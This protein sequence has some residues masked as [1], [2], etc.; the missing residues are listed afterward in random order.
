MQ[1]GFI[2]H[3]PSQEQNGYSHLAC[4]S[5]SRNMRILR[6]FKVAYYYFIEPETFKLNRQATFYHV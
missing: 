1:I 5:E 2:S 3:T 4:T 6:H